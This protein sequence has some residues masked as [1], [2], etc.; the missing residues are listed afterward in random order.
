M[1]IAAFYRT[2][3]VFTRSYSY[4][5]KGV[6][7]TGYLPFEYIKGNVQPWKQGVVTNL[8]EVGVIY[9]DYRTLYLKKQPTLSTTGIPAGAVVS[10]NPLVYFEGNWYDVQGGQD[11]TLAGRAPKHF[12]YLCIRNNPGPGSAAIP[13]PTPMP[14]LVESFTAIVNELNQLTPLV[15]NRL[16]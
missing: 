14:M 16:M 7:K 15:V 9:K 6:A 3:V 10:E 4:Y 13:E 12:K 2:W 8:T 11:W 1:S 5:E